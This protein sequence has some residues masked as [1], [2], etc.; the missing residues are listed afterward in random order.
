MKAK[1]IL[2]SDTD[3][4]NPYFSH[5]PDLTTLSDVA[6]YIGERL[7]IKAYSNDGEFIV[8]TKHVSAIK[9]ALA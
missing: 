1:L 5:F 3:L 7:W 2:D 4:T 6:T 8:F 9:E